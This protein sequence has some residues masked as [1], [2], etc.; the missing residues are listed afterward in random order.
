MLDKYLNIPE[1]IFYKSFVKL[2]GIEK[3]FYKHRLFDKTKRVILYLDYPKYIHLGDALWFEPLARVL[4]VNFDFAVCCPA[5]FDFYFSSL[6]YKII[7]K[8]QI[9]ENDL[10]VARTE[11]AYHL[12]KREV[13]WINFSYANVTKPLI[14]EVLNNISDYLGLYPPTARPQVLELT[15]AEIDNTALKFG[16]DPKRRYMVLNNYLHS[17][18]FSVNIIDYQKAQQR[19]LNFARKYKIKEEINIIHTGTA[20]QK[21]HDN[22]LHD[23]VDLDLRG[24]TSVKDCFLIAALKNVVTYMGFDSFWLHLFN[25]YDKK[26]FIILRPGFSNTLKKQIINYVAVPYMSDDSKVTFIN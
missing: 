10:L 7:D 11:L 3:C 14:N 18:K 21:H 17:L 5:Y 19:L 26:S 4:A 6:G 22:N 23:F 9:S 1:K 8:S 20:E 2:N 12:R 16:L 24:R 25:I 15:P 13:F